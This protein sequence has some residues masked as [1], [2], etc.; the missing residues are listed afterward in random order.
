MNKMADPGLE[1]NP[2]EALDFLEM[3]AGDDPVA[4]CAMDPDAGPA[5][6]GLVRVDRRQAL[7]DWLAKQNAN[8][9]VYYTLNI[10][11]PGAKGVHGKLRKDEIGAIRGV[12]AD[13]DPNDERPRDALLRLADE[14]AKRTDFP[15]TLIVDSGNGVQLIWLFDKPIDCD[16]GTRERAEAQGRG[17]AK[18]FG[19]DRRARS[20]RSMRR[21]P[22]A[23]AVERRGARQASRAETRQWRTAGAACMAAR[24][25]RGRTGIGRSSSRASRPRTSSTSS[26]CSSGAARP[27]RSAPRR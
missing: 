1:V 5:A 6:G 24:R 17:L 27:R 23:P 10:P 3:I 21:T 8:R 4:L 16:A 26:P 11:R 13:L 22:P 19:G 18:F 2:D 12:A 14:W 9:N 20:R 25:R 15:P 7:G